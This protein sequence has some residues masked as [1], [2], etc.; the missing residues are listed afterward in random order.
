V[1]ITRDG[2]VNAYPAFSPDGRWLA[3]QSAKRGGIWLVPATGGAPRRVS[4]TGEFPA[5]SPDGRTL[6]FSSFAGHSSQAVLWTVKPDGTARAQLTTAGTP[7][8]GHVGPTWSP[9]GRFILFRVGRHQERDAWIVDAAGGVPRR[10]A[11]NIGP[12]AP[13]FSKDG[14]AVFA[15][16][17]PARA[18]VGG[19]CLRRER[20]RMRSSPRAA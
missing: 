7:V 12:A 16:R 8:G 5:W 2:G 3:Y 19:T 15:S 1:A 6:V 20:L 14:R 4:D 17:S 13:Q 11:T 9:D 10:I 18:R